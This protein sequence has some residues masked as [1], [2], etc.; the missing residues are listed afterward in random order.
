MSSYSGSSFGPPHLPHV[1][2]SIDWLVLEP[3]VLNVVKRPSAA[4]PQFEA[5]AQPYVKG[6]KTAHWRV[7][8]LHHYL[9]SLAASLRQDL[10]GLPDTKIYG[11]TTVEAVRSVRVVFLT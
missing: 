3:H 5:A 1:S 7:A 8:F 11:D 4:S 9:D 6:I 10:F 2:F